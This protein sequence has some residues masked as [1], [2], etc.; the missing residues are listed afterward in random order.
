MTKQAVL[1]AAEIERL[2][3]DRLCEKCKVREHHWFTDEG[4]LC[5]PCTEEFRK[6]RRGDELADRIEVYRKALM[7]SHADRWSMDDIA[8]AAHICARAWP[9]R[10]GRR[11]TRSKPRGAAHMTDGG[12]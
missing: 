3:P 5:N 8:E 7:V 1:S 10:G 9:A 2:G 12:S 6:Q 4:Y 11:L